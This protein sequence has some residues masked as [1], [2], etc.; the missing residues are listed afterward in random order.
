MGGSKILYYEIEW[1]R[2][3]NGIFWTPYITM[4]SDNYFASITGLTSG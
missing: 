1:D 2:G 4:P 3:T